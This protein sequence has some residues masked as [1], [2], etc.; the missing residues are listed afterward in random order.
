MDALIPA[1]G[2]GARLDRPG[3]PK[4]LIE[5]DGVPLILRTLRQMQAAGVTRV[6]IVTGFRSAQVRRAL[7]AVPGLSIDSQSAPEH[8]QRGPGLL[9]PLRTTSPGEAC[10]VPEG[11]LVSTAALSMKL[12]FVYNRRWRFGLG[13]SLLAARDC[14]DGPFLLAMADHIYDAPLIARMAAAAPE[15]DG[16]VALVDHSPERVFDLD[17]AVKVVCEDGRPVRFL[18]HCDAPAADAGLFLATPALFDALEACDALDLAHA[19]DLM[20]QQG[21]VRQV[22]ADAGWDDVDTPAALVHAELRLRAQRRQRAARTGEAAPTFTFQTGRPVQTDVVVQRGAVAEPSRFGVV[23][24]ASASS[25]VFVFTDET[26][27]TLDGDAFVRDL[28]DA[29]HR[30][31]RIVIPDGEEAKTVSN[32]A[33]LVERVLS[34]GID[35]RSVLISLGGGVVCNVCGFVAATLYRGIGLVHVPTTLMAQCDAAISHKQAVNGAR[36]KNMVGAYYAPERI[37]VDVD[38][39]QTQTDRALRDGLAEVLKHALAQDAGYLEWLMDPSLD[40]RDPAFLERVVRRNIALKCAIMAVDPQEKAEGMVLQYGHTVGHPIEHL[41]GYA[42]THVE[43]V[44]VG[45][46]IAARVAHTL[47]ALDDAGLAA[48][49]AL[50]MRWGLPTQVPASVHTADI[51][52]SLTYNKTWRTEGTRM[53]LVSVPGTLWSVSGAH[54]IPVCDAVIADAVDATRGATDDAID[55]ARDHRDDHRRRQRHRARVRS[56][57]QSAGRAGD[58]P[59]ATIGAPRR[60]R[61]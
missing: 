47:G 21:R 31:H 2:R 49:R 52:K 38:V 29:G 55:P 45:M 54:A 19:A 61:R 28:E 9:G 25:P 35:E 6:V 33:H 4:P 59:G 14:F 11:P 51:L 8:S 10:R 3:T 32:Y 44:A 27:N 53:A 34:K 7:S 43:A 12:E 60:P 5:V 58:R 42:L 18:R 40:L 26:V 22:V 57:V 36:G 15:P 20:A 39:L 17:D 56:A 46:L 41:S 37:I 16:L 13:S 50:L 23:P 30:V 1:A 24:A 48:H